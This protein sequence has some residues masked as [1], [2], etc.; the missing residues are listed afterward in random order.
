M[1]WP[2][3]S[4]S[5]KYLA[6]LAI[7]NTPRN[8]L[9]SPAK[10]LMSRNLRSQ[11]PRKRNAYR[12]EAI[13]AEQVDVQLKENQKKMKQQFDKGTRM[14]PA[15]EIGA[16]VMMREDSQQLWR[17]ATVIGE[18]DA[19]R[20]YIVRDSTGQTKIRNKELL[21]RTPK[22]KGK[23]SEGKQKAEEEWRLEELQPEIQDDIPIKES[24]VRSTRCGRT[25]R[26]PDRLDL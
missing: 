12:S 4:S 1:R 3:N 13:K 14:R 26:K 16:Q 25:I 15:M 20:S 2:S 18:A 24:P 5:K 9:P 8:N 10:M 22:D 23:E 11:V 17:P 7:R 6:L 19:P 21:R